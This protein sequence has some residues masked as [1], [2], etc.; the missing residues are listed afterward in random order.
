MKTE[1]ILVFVF[2]CFVAINFVAINFVPW[3]PLHGPESQH[4]GVSWKDIHEFN[5]IFFSFFDK[6][7]VYVEDDELPK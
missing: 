4:C 6:A 3:G 1:C 5:L 7:P 2:L